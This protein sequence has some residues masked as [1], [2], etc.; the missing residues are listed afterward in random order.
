[1][2]SECESSFEKNENVRQWSE[3]LSDLCFRCK[4]SRVL[5]NTVAEKSTT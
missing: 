4:I 1:L 2:A 3:D 5:K